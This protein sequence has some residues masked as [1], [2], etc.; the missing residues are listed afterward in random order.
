MAYRRTAIVLVAAWALPMLADDAR[1]AREYVVS[2][3]TS[4]HRILADYVTS[5]RIKYAWAGY[6][7]AYRV[8]FLSRER[9]IVASTETVRIPGYQVRVGRNAANAA[10]I[11]RMP[12]NEGSHV[13]EWCVI[14]PFQR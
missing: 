13:A 9:V 3:P 7:D 14:D 1:T 4:I 12:C 5:H 10:R 11:V 2:P 8:T 6:W